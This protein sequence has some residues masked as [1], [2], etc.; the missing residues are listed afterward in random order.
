MLCELQLVGVQL[1][2][3]P[4]QV[5]LQHPHPHHPNSLVRSMVDFHAALIL[6]RWQRPPR[7]R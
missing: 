1:C 2:L 7:I 4:A 6:Q 5:N 3:A